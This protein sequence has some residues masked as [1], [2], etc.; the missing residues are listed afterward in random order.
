MIS[1]VRYM[2]FTLAVCDCDKIN[3]IMYTASR[4]HVYLLMLDNQPE[5]PIMKNGCEC[6]RT[7][8]NGSGSGSGGGEDDDTQSRTVF[9]YHPPNKTRENNI[10]LKLFFTPSQNYIYV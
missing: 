8:I 6:R 2:A 7:T 9:L 3:A 5:N 10:K 1:G 4:E